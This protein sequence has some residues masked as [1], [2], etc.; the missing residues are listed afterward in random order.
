MVLIVDCRPQSAARYP[1]EIAQPSLSKQLV[2]SGIPGGTICSLGVPWIWGGLQVFDGAIRQKPSGE[3]TLSVHLPKGGD[4][5]GGADC[6][7]WLKYGRIP[8]QKR[9]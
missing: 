5:A 7:F 2:G 8:L 4:F 3:F 6:K 1:L 9:D